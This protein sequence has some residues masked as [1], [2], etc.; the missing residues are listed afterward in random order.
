M[1]KNSLSILYL[2][3]LF[4][5][6]SCSTFKARVVTFEDGFQSAGK[7]YKIEP[8]NDQKQDLEWRNLSRRIEK[9]LIEKGI[10]FSQNPDYKIIFY[11]QV[12]EK[13]PGLQNISVD[14]NLIA[15]S[16]ASSSAGKSE[17]VFMFDIFEVKTKNKV[18]EIKIISEPSEHDIY[19]TKECF[20][21]AFDTN[22]PSPN[23]TQKI[24][25]ISL[26]CEKVTEKRNK[27]GKKQK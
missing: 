9:L 24:I 16:G 10:V 14:A 3:A 23:A 25:Q 2:L 7:T 19:D 17:K 5:V 6:A 18:Y 15:F 26:P 8:T 21:E 11:Y 22:F 13:T 27:A 1:K 20:L 4:I 12:N